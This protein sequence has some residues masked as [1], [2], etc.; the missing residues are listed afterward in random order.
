MGQPDQDRQFAGQVLGG[1]LS[2]LA[3]LIAVVGILLTLH[4]RVQGDFDLAR[5]FETLTI[6][7]S[8]VLVLAG[9]TA[10]ASVAYLRGAPVR[11]GAIVGLLALLL[12]A[13][14]GVVIAA[15]L[16]TFF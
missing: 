2:L 4:E 11:I 8:G 9:A 10:G 1:V 7:A 6:G 15:V 3:I 13:V 12:A 14:I 16:L 5:S